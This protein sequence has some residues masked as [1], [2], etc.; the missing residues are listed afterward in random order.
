MQPTQTIPM[1]QYWTFEDLQQ[2]E[3]ENWR[4]Y[5]I[6]DGALVVS[7]GAAPRHE[8]A[9]ARLL[10]TIASFVP[11]GYEALGALTVDLHPSY[12]IPDLVVVHSRVF[13]ANRPR[14]DPRDVLLAVEVV[15]PSSVSTDRLVKPAQYAAAG[16]AAYWRVETDPIS[17]TAYLL[18]DGVYAELGTWT[19]GQIAEIAEPFPVRI[20]LADLVPSGESPT[21]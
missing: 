6:M 12:R 3:D 21:P 4:R 17:V 15:S 13:D 20:T 14:V 9:S 11:E 10:R 1:R 8:L 5:E 19:P 16:I 7:P 2:I 18:R